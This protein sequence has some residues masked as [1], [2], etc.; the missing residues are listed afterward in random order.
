MKTFR[1]L[2]QL[3]IR[4]LSPVAFLVLFLWVPS[5]VRA[6][7]PAPQATPPPPAQPRQ[8]KF[9]KPVE[10]TL[11][12][13]LRVIVIERSGTPL[14]AAQLI[15][16]NGGEVDPPELA[17]LSNMTADLLTKGTEKR[18]A[19]QI[20]EA[21]EALGGSLD[22]SARWDASRVGVNVMSS[23]IAPAT[24][25]LADVVRRPTFK[26]DEIER[27]RQQTLD[28]LIVELGEP[29]SIARYVA[30]RI[31]FGDAPYGQPLGGTPESI[32]RINRNDIGKFHGR[33]YRPD[34]AILVL[35]GDIKAREAFKLA[36]QYFG[37]WKKPSESLP[38]VMMPKP[39]ATAGPRVIVIDKPDAGQ[40]AVTVTR[41]GITRQDPDYFIGIVANSVLSGYSGRLN[42]EIRIKRGL[43]YGAGSSLEARRDTGPF[44]A[45]AQTKNQSAAQVAEL[46]M[47]EVKRLST[48][49]VPD[50]EM[51]PRKAVVIGNFARNLETAAG[52][53]AQV[54][55]L[56][57]YGI[58]FDEINR[59]IGNVQTITGSDVERFAGKRLDAKTT[60]IVIVGNAKEFL[61]E[62]RKQYPQVEVIPVAE[63][64]LN[65]ALLR[66]KQA[67]N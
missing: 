19:T 30:A 10:K 36:Q 21:I 50:I 53:V 7:S 46:L 48:E 17:G 25:I 29:G 51:I 58:S 18:T 44:S 38:A 22:S 45:T 3:P 39:L 55:T 61:L 43:S 65:T 16:K 47:K 15:I 49:P 41:A 56:A 27:L 26:E 37:D 6:Q 35:G 33:Y 66:K 52:L 57:L 14:V 54:A 64:D 24:E 12:N 59:Y 42:Q 5:A 11:P 63:L 62:L 8:V 1:H 20:A 28:D 34:N 32:A 9:P 2:V 31:V 67:T 23:K 4:S 40:A 13:G 60:S